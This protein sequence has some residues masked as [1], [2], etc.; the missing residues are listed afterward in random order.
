MADRIRIVV[1]IP[2]TQ[3]GFAAAAA[4][5]AE[6]ADVT[7]T[8][9]YEPEQVLWSAMAG[10]RYAA[11]YLGRL[12]DAGRDGLAVIATMQDVAARYGRHPDGHDLRLLVASVRSRRAFVD[13]LRLGTGAVTIPVHLFEELTEHDATL[14]AEQTFLADA[15]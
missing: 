7:M 15:R 4:L 12:D 11:P 9:V 8:A 1:K 13:L 3:A 14:A 6:A 5:A 10:A 2:A